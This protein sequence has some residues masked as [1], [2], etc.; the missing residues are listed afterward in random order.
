MACGTMLACGEDPVDLWSMKFSEEQWAERASCGSFQ[1][2]LESGLW[3][4]AG[5]EEKGER[6]DLRS[7]ESSKVPPRQGKQM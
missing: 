7:E 5:L 2:D 4:G 3:F 1:K 6:N